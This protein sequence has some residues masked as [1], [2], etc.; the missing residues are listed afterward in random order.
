MTDLRQTAAIAILLIVMA[1]AG[2]TAGRQS[3][4]ADRLAC[5]QGWWDT[6]AALNAC[7]YE[8]EAAD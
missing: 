4:E 2:F 7:I 6:M 5:G 8:L 3:A 1:L